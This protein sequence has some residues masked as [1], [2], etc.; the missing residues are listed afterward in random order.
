MKVD[1]KI[2]D[3]F[4]LHLKRKNLLSICHIKLQGTVDIQMKHSGDSRQ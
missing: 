1:K 4:V 2:L 3:L